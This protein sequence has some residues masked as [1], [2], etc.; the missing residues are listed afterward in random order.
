MKK[1]NFTQVAF[2]KVRDFFRP[3]FYNGRNGLAK[4]GDSPNKDRLWFI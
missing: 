1:N 4:E 2:K 3:M